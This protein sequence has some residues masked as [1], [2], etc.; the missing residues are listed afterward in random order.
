MGTG[1]GEAKPKNFQSIPHMGTTRKEEKPKRDYL[2]V[3]KGS[4]LLNNIYHH[5]ENYGKNCD[6]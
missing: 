4:F 3:I 2:Q 5:Q 6:N 1:W